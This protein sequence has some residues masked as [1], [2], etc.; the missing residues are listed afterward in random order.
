LQRFVGAHG[1][2]QAGKTL[3]QH[4]LAGARRA[5]HEHAVAASRSDLQGSFRRRLPLDVGQV[6]IGRFLLLR[7]GLQLAPARHRLG[8]RVAGQE[9]PDHVQQVQGAINL[10]SRHQRGFLGTALG[11]HQSGFGRSLQARQGQA[12][13]QCAADRT[14]L[15][16]QR[17]LAGELVTG[18][19]ARVDLAAGGQDA[20]RNRQ[21]ETAGVLGQVGGRQ[22][23]GDAL[24][25]REFEAGVLDGRT[26]PF[27]R[28]LDFGFGQAHQ[29]EAGQ[30]VGQMNLNTHGV[31]LHAQQG[32]ALH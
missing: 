10:G 27:A 26:H 3:G 7:A 9:L 5:H 11:Q 22:V 6:G 2:Q 29:R 24:V 23:D 32:A 14:Q 17:Q 18:E 20:Q 8:R 19:L 4:R 21:I 30:P 16:A 1:G 31:G 28:F 13:G 15:P 12:H 25:G